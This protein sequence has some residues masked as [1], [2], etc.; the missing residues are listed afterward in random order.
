MFDL[1]VDILQEE[2]QEDHPTFLIH[3]YPKSEGNEI[4]Q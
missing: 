1:N 3:Y 2:I 4:H